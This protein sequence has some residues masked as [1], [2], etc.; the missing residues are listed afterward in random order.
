MPDRIGDL[1][2][3]C[4]VGIIELTAICGFVIAVLIW[5]DALFG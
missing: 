2:C 4:V 1:I 3:E 5:M